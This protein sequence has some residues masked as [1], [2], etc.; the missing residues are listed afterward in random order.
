MNSSARRLNPRSR[1][2][3]SFSPDQRGGAVNPHAGCALT[4]R[5]LDATESGCIFF[6]FDLYFFHVYFISFFF[7]FLIL[8][9]HFCILDI[10]SFVFSWSSTSSCL[11]G[12]SPFGPLRASPNAGKCVFRRRWPCRVQKRHS[13]R[14][15]KPKQRRKR[16]RRHQP[17]KRRERGSAHRRKTRTASEKTTKKKPNHYKKQHRKKNRNTQR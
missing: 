10:S 9:F 12:F 6:L 4:T 17:L 2:G 13:R 5:I 1:V 3:A 14:P 15:G 11:L 16:E 7:S 8:F